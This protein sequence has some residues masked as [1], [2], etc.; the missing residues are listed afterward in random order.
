MRKITAVL[1][2]AVLWLQ[3][4]AAL[5][6]SSAWQSD[7][8]TQSLLSEL[9]IMSGDDDG[10]FKYDSYV[11]RAEM[12]KLAVASSSAKN[13]VA[14]GMK[15]SPFSD[16]K[17]DLW[18]A[19]YIRAAVTAG[20]VSGYIDGTF[21]PDGTVTYEEA[22][23]MMLKVLGYT[24][25][26]F[27][28]SYPYG[29]VGMAERLEMTDGVNASVGDPLTRRQVAV[30]ICNTLDTKLKDSQSDLITVHDCAI[31]E[32][33]T[34]IADSAEDSTLASDEISTSSGIY[35][36][37]SSRFD[38]DFVGMR[39]D[40]VVKDG[41][42]YVSFS[43]DG[44]VS[45]DRY[46]I[47][48]PLNDA[49]LCYKEGNNSSM[50]ELSI[51]STTTCYKD[52]KSYTYSQLRSEMEMGDTIRIRYNDKGEI[53]Y[54]NFSE[55]DMDGPIKVVGSGWINSFDTDEST[56]IMR[57]GSKVSEGEIK[58]NDIIYYSGTLN[59]I[60][61]YSKKITGVYES[62]APSKDMPQTVTVSGV[63]YEVEGVEAFNDLSSSGTLSYGDT[64][65][66][67]MGKDGNKVAGVVT[68]TAA[69]SEQVVGYAIGSGRDTFLN[70]D[71]TTY[72]SYYLNIVTPDGTVY[73]YPTEYDKSG[74]VNKVVRAAV[75]NGYASISTVNTVSSLTGYVD[76]SKMLIGSKTA[77]S[78]IKIIDISKI[79]GS[80]TAVYAKTYMQ[81]IDGVTLGSGSAAYYSTNSNGEISELI[82]QNVTGDMYNYGMVVSSGTQSAGED[83][84]HKTFSILSDNAS[85]SAS[86]FSL[87]AGVPVQ[88]A[89]EGG[90]ASYASKLREYT[91]TVTELTQYKVVMGGKEYLLS[92]KV[93]VFKE[94]TSLGYLE[95]SINDAISGDYKYYCY[96]DK[97]ESEGGRVRV[98]VCK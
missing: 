76:Y 41:K 87:T 57:D 13:S 36:L 65:T 52:S 53:D 29:Q 2:A 4:G 43:P 79:A 69:V 6:A 14:S 33:V 94:I 59:M 42:Y 61:A 26:D 24:D 30:L 20:I 38:P 91:G 63:S 58:T 83:A 56:K 31:I 86:K 16:V 21:R 98:I 81:R 51:S 78:D 11:T 25:A 46:I 39:G 95:M 22:C 49:I 90:T 60:L 35:R 93:K 89:A 96:Y 19:P 47:Y 34:I 75:K 15:F 97:T 72:T 64:I 71:G 17:S 1:A 45:S 68:N 10:D 5:A 32:D 54:I 27:G 3:C 48:S 92:D 12:A 8:R 18:A 73:K 37:K 55:N 50:I 80:D 84:T 82:L 28:A 74:N 44:E 70:S 88:F 9:G 40:M 85:Y 7:D 62:A 67:L 23:T 77:A 66:I